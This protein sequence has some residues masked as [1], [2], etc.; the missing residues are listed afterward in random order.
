M[1]VVRAQ[2]APRAWASLAIALAIP[3][4]ATWFL[5]R[6]ALD[7]Q[8]GRAVVQPWRWWT[9]AWVHLSPF[10]LL[11]NLLGCAVVA[12]FGIVAGLP[13]HAAWAWLAAWPLTHV[14]L[15]IQPQLQNYGGL[16]GVLHAGVAIA[17][18]HL[19]LDPPGRDRLVGCA[20]LV[21]LAVKL[22]LEHAWLA[23]PQAVPGWDIR[24]APLAH[25]TGTVAGLLCGVTA[26][27]V[28]SH[29]HPVDS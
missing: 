19:A 25:L 24:I 6:E 26:R 15:A 9:A 1:R 23:T 7:W 29:R 3:A 14:A 2:P 28:A 8:P 4:L 22:A 16:S 20:V 18:L 17:A 11:A 13:R 12:A 21:G 27:W 5:P 10:H